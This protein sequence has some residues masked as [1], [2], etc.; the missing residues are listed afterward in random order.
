MDEPTLYLAGGLFNAGE[1]LHL[2]YLEKHL[3]LLGHKV[4]LP[5]REALNFF[6]GGSF[7]VKGIVEHCRVRCEDAKNIF[8]G[9]SDG[10]DADSGTAIEYGIAITATGRAIVYR[11]D[12][13]TDTEKELGM[14]AMFQARGTCFLYQPCYF[15]ELDEVDDYYAKLARIIHESLPLVTGVTRPEEPRPQGNA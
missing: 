6:D 14:N 5:Q 10:A 3:K 7:D 11:T 4:V 9:S 1:R 8:V 2:L 12:F 15:T 13:R